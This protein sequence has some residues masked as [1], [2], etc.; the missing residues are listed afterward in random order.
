[1]LYV[2]NAPAGRGPYE[3]EAT[4]FYQTLGARYAAELFM[5]DVPE[6]KHFAKLYNAADPRPEMLGQSI[7]IL[8]D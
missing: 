4:L 7:R 5:Q 6:M 8:K 1:M 2:V 3:I